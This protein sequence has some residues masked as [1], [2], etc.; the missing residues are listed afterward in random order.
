MQVL[1]TMGQSQS[2][3]N[4]NTSSTTARS[5]PNPDDYK[6]YVKWEGERFAEGRFRY[7]IKGTWVR[8]REKQG[9]NC[10]V[11]HLK[12]SYTWQKTDW[13]TTVKIHKEAEELAKEFNKFSQTNNP[14]HFTEVVVIKCL[15]RKNPS[16]PNGPRLDEYCTT[17]DFLAG[18]FKK[19]VNNYGIYSEET[20][21]TATSMP[22]FM[23]WSWYHTKG[24]K[25]IADL[26]GIRDS[27]GYTLTD[28]VI[29]SLSGEYGATDMGVEGMAIFFY[30]HKCNSFCEKLPRPDQNSIKSQIPYAELQSCI[31]MTRTI[32]LQQL[33]T[34]YSCEIRLSVQMRFQLVTTFRAIAAKEITN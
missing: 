21:S 17:E 8:P 5:K 16:N 12:S 6:Y 19:W 24:E 10:V 9:Q 28:P 26:Q 18:N 32:Q 11:K 7:A 3:N 29:L 14:I 33:A 34:T 4:Y 1:H 2:A 30:L 13:D 23:H 20:V 15:Y 22:A 27:N 25:M 31:Q